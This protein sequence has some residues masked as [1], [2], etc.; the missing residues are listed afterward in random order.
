MTFSKLVAGGPRTAARGIDFSISKLE[1]HYAANWINAVLDQICG[2]CHAERDHFDWACG[3]WQM[4]RAR[5]MMEAICYEV[6][7]RTNLAGSAPAPWGACERARAPPRLNHRPLKYRRPE[8]VWPHQPLVYA[9]HAANIMQISPCPH[10]SPL[11]FRHA[12]PRLG[13]LRV[14]WH[15]GTGF[16]SKRRRLGVRDKAIVMRLSSKLIGSF[17]FFFKV[18]MRI[19]TL[20]FS[21]IFRE[22]KVKLCFINFVFI[23]TL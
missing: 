9:A 23:F 12:Q 15:A 22:F 14:F 4:R 19:L 18:Q 7:V 21:L 5:S 3:D 20:L 2:R 13:F 1:P 17:H 8:C 11:C 10:P 16:S 6:L